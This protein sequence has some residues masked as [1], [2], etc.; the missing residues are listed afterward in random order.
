[1]YIIVSQIGVPL[2]RHV[3]RRFLCPLDILQ[4]SADAE[5]CY[6]DFELLAEQSSHILQAYARVER[7]LVT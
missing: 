2:S 5:A 4:G 3:L 1:M 6:D 7:K